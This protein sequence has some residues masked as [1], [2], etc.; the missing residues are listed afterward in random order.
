MLKNSENDSEAEDEHMHGE[1]SFIKVSL[2]NLFNHIY[3]PLAQDE[4]FYSGEE[5]GRSDKEYSKFTREK[6]AEAKE[7]C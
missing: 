3:G 6:E 7:L 1:R 5:A 2:V 4:D